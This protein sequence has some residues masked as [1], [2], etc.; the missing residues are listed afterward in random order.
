[1]VM[2]IPPITIPVV[3]I[4][5]VSCGVF[6]ELMCVCIYAEYGE[7]HKAT[8]FKVRPIIGQNKV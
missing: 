3:V 7:T 8:L 1:M 4:R 6:N 2:I 5:F